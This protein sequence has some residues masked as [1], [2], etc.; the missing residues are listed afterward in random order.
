MEAVDFNS[1]IDRCQYEAISG[2]MRKLVQLKTSVNITPVLCLQ[3]DC[4][5]EMEEVNQKLMH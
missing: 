2:G 4:Y 5:C 1:E 3:L